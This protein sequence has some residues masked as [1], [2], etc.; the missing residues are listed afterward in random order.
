MP[1][2][3][4]EGNLVETVQVWGI[5]PVS[6][7]RVSD[8]EN[9]LWWKAP[10]PGEADSL[11]ADDPRLDESK[12]RRADAMAMR[13]QRTAEPGI[14]MGMHMSIFNERQSDG[15]YDFR[16]GMDRYWMPGKSV[17]L[18]LVPIKGASSPRNPRRAVRDRQRVPVRGLP[19]RQEPALI[20]LGDAQEMLRMGAGVLYDTEGELDPE[21]GGH[22]S[23]QPGACSRCWSRPSRVSPPAEARGVRRLRSFWKASSPILSDW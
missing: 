11:R 15:S 9:I 18:T 5:E 10:A 8:F 4:E 21:T 16:N 2:G 23:D 22:K 14:V 3:T 19:D 7:S 20:S 17:E 12:D 13:D 1:Y 6:F